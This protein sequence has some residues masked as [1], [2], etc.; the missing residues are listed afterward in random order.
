MIRSALVLII[1]AI[2]GAAGA[3][4]VFVDNRAPAGGDG[5]RERPYATIAQG[6]SSG[7]IVYVAESDAPYN[8]S[9]VLRKAQMLIGS[10]FGL[11]ALQT[12]LHVD[13]G[14]TGVPAMKGLGPA[15]HGT[16][17]VTG[18]NVIAGCTLFAGGWSGI[19]G[20]GAIGTLTV[21]DVY[22][23]SS[24]AGFAIYL[25]EQ[26]GKVDI[27]GGS[28]EA[29]QAGSG[30]GLDGGYGEVVIDRFPISGDFTTAV[31]IQNRRSGAVTFKRGSKVRVRDAFDDA[32][33]IAAMPRPGTVR[34]E[35]SIEVRGR[36]RG[37]VV[38]N[39][40]SLAIAGSSNVSTANAAALDV[41]DSGV[42]LSFQ[43]VSAEGVAPG[44]LDEGI[45]LDRVHGHVA[46]TG[47]GGKIGTGGAI[48]H[49]QG[50][51][52]RIAQASN[53]RMAGIT[54]T[55]SGV[56]KPARGVRCAGNFDVNSTAICRAALYLRHVS[57]SAFDNIVIDGDSAMGINANNIR[58]VT[59]GGLDVHRAGDETFE[60]GVLVQ[61]ASGTITFS[62]SSFADNA[63]SEMLI[64]QRFNKGKIALERCVFA[65]TGRP[66]VAAHLIE[67]RTSGNG[68][69]DVQLRNGDLRDNLGGAIDASAAESSSLAIDILDS[70]IQHFGHGVVAVASR[71]GGKAQITMQRNSVVA[72]ASDRPLVG[73]S[74]NDSASVCA[75]ISANRF[76]GAP[77]TVIHLTAS[78]HSTMY[79]VGMSSSNSASIASANGGAAA[80][81]DG[82]AVAGPPCR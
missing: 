81:I 42:E 79:I 1:L 67:V 51:G 2:A 28:I 53:V 6:V 78:P 73:V 24:R 29:A 52:I 15:I 25:Q 22:I 8:E 54:L 3:S 43:S 23:K 76:S 65:A 48:V 21:R 17:S 36:R 77:G 61:E 32:V 27:A 26:Q 30:I 55:D 75:D 44:T 10:A 71:Q 58:N 45:I 74:A 33:V 16:I 35:D 31:R 38:N 68:S 60:S 80:V 50:N 14:V 46:I 12:D 41:R 40:A 69:A 63:G 62:R 64:E 72:Q 49:A 70:S 37:L 9:V 5:S 82:P 59:F 18:D 39:V 47:I 20:S 57:D 11:D 19:A 4:V 7:T 34:F 66:D 56:N 13:S